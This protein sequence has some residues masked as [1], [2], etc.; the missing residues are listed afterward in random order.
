MSM[1]R[2]LVGITA[3]VALLATAVAA[4]AHDVRI[5]PTDE[6]LILPLVQADEHLETSPAGPIDFG[7]VPFGFTETREIDVENRSQQTQT[8]VIVPPPG[9]ESLLSVQPASFSLAPQASRRVELAYSPG[10]LGDDLSGEMIVTGTDVRG[11]PEHS[12]IPLN[13]TGREPVRRLRLVRPGTTTPI[14]AL[15]FGLVTVGDSTDFQVELINDGE[16]EVSGQIADLASF[17]SEPCWWDVCFAEAGTGADPQHYTLAAG[18][19]MILEVVFRPWREWAL[20]HHTVHFL[21]GDEPV[22]LALTVEALDPEETDD[23][24]V[25]GH[26][27]LSRTRHDFGSLAPASSAETTI[28]LANTGT[29]TVNGRLAGLAPGSHC[30]LTG[31][32]G[33]TDGVCF[34]SAD[35]PLQS[36]TLPPG[37]DRSIQVRFS[38]QAETL[39][40]AATVHFTGGAEPMAFTAVGSAVEGEQQTPEGQGGALVPIPID[41]AGM[42]GMVN[43]NTF[44]SSTGIDRVS[45]M[46]G[47]LVLSIPVGQ[48][49]RIGPS[50]SHGLSLTYNS[51]A[52]DFGSLTDGIPWGGNAEEPMSAPAYGSNAGLGWRLS[53]GE[54]YEKNG[55]A[56][57]W[58]NRTFSF[59]WLYV[60]PDGSRVY[61]DGTGTP[62][63]YH[64]RGTAFL[65]LVEDPGGQRVT[66]Q[67]GDGSQHVFDKTTAIGNGTATQCDRNGGCWLITGIEDAFG[68][69]AAVSY[70]GFAGAAPRMT[71][72]YPFNRRVTVD[73][74]PAI[75]GAGGDLGDMHL[76]VTAVTV[77]T[78]DGGS[79]TYRLNYDQ[80]TIVRGCPY[81]ARMVVNHRRM[82]VPLLRQLVVPHGDTYELRY[83]VDEETTAGEA[84]RCDLLAGT[85]S[86]VTLPTKASIEYRWKA[87]Q[88]PALCAPEGDNPPIGSQTLVAPFTNSAGVAE[89]TLV[90]EDGRR[91]AYTLYR[92]QLDPA[93]L[94]DFMPFNGGCQRRNLQITDVVH[95]PNLGSEEAPRY[96]VERFFHTVTR[97]GTSGVWG[98]AA[99][100][101]PINFA[102]SIPTQFGTAWLSREVAECGAE[103]FEHASCSVQRRHYRRYQLLGGS[104]CSPQEDRPECHR[105]REAVHVERDAYSGGKWIDRRHTDWD[106]RGHYRRTES[107]SNFRYDGAILTTWNHR[108]Y[109]GGRDLGFQDSLPG[110]GEKWLLDLFTQTRSNTTGVWRAVDSHFDS[111]T[112]ALVC[113]RTHEATPAAEE[114]IA[115]SNEDIA[116]RTTRNGSGY[117]TREEVA[118][119]DGGELPPA[120]CPTAAADMS[121]R[122]FHEYSSGERSRSQP[123]STSGADL[124]PPSLHLLIDASTGLPKGACDHGTQP[125]TCEKYGYDRLGRRTLVDRGWKLGA[126][127]DL[128]LKPAPQRLV[129]TEFV[130][131]TPAAGGAVLIAR[132][133]QG[134]ILDQAKIVFDGLGNEQ[135]QWWKDHLGRWVR[136]TVFTHGRGFKT[137]ETTPWLDGGTLDC[138]DS[139]TECRTVFRRDIYGRTTETKSPALNRH[140]LPAPVDF[141][142]GVRVR[143]FFERGGGAIHFERTER[144]YSNTRTSR[145]VHRDH[146]GRVLRV[147]EGVEGTPTRRTLIDRNGA[148]TVTTLDPLEGGW[149]SQQRRESHDGRGFLTEEAY[150]EWSGQ[151]TVYTYDARG[152]PRTV[153]RPDGTVL[154]HQRDA[155]GRVVK[156]R[157]QGPAGRVLKEFEYDDTT[158]RLSA[159]VRWNDLSCSATFAFSLCGPDAEAKVRQDFDYD[160]NG[161][162][163]G[164]RTEIWFGNTLVSAVEQSWQMDAQGQVES[165]GYPV[166]V[167]GSQCPIDIAP[168][169]TV[170]YGYEHGHLVGIATDGRTLVEQSYHPNG[171]LSRID[172]F[173]AAG[174][175]S[176]YEVIGTGDFGNPVMKGIEL[177]RN[178]ADSPEWSSGEFLYSGRGTVRWLFGRSGGDFAFLYDELDR[179]TQYNRF[180]HLTDYAYDPYDNL[181]SMTNLPGA[182]T[183]LIYGVSSASNRVTSHNGITAISYDPLG[184]LQRFENVWIAHDA[185]GQQRAYLQDAGGAPD[186]GD[187]YGYQ[188][189]YLYDADDRRVALFDRIP[190][191]SGPAGERRTLQLYLRDRTGETLREVQTLW[192]ADDLEHH[193][194][195]DRVWAAG[196]LRAYDSGDGGLRHVHLDHLGSPKTLTNGVA[197]VDTQEFDPWGLRIPGTGAIEIRTA[198][199]GHEIDRNDPAALAT[200]GFGVTYHLGARSYAPFLGRFLSPDPARDPSSWTLYGYAG[201]DPM[202]NGDLAGLACNNM[203]GNTGIECIVRE[204]SMEPLE[205]LAKSVGDGRFLDAVKDPQRKID[206]ETISAGSDGVGKTTIAPSTGEILSPG[207]RAVAPAIADVQR[208][209]REHAPERS[210]RKDGGVNIHGEIVV[211]EKNPKVRDIAASRPIC[212]PCAATLD[213]AGIRTASPRKVVKAAK[214]LPGALGTAGQLLGITVLV[215]DLRNATSTREGAKLVGEFFFGTSEVGCGQIEGC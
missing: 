155:L 29:A 181:L 193:G 61:F 42:R 172:H 117:V 10:G 144:F 146:L 19:S 209:I 106:G 182:G 111:T 40:F 107:R 15:D 194:Y 60:T 141:L 165:V 149:P 185:F 36:F 73:Y 3:W 70:L 110:V 139:G 214:K 77:P 116:V 31:D 9:T 16:M 188:A 187:G 14:T 59:P 175:R 134:G 129:D 8:V 45:T 119:G 64:S 163:D 201:N 6:D 199:G 157:A 39:S 153:S 101:L 124:G 44:L 5:L 178:G 50:M 154:Y 171:Q 205:R 130:Y 115:P 1:R 25:D 2:A 197:V 69:R 120:G 91:Q 75:A 131:Q 85:V 162:L 159:A 7:A 136:R 63:V 28:V 118:G 211:M 24:V 26:L 167:D 208:G 109:R 203:I 176:W 128:E 46:T 108:D 102:A 53:L 87:W 83:N 183:D 138:G 164:R 104:S 103:D 86:R 143:T 184:R 122:T 96:K 121:F 100:G 43:Q 57:H 33:P 112:G 13:G 66:L 12:S 137:A 125:A 202:A 210:N 145:V 18:E 161:F 72:T 180:G 51:S 160:S 151:A 177:F 127:G 147:L 186:P 84:D 189:I 90:R 81:N 170:D 114:A 168:N 152:K 206:G 92:P 48:P 140:D 95:G 30:V 32:E 58:P 213:E 93:S 215:N 37:G 200:D 126:E 82:S 78:F 192:D 174:N 65:R 204:G 113:Q 94:E 148:S 99:Y 135:Q 132:L 74:S 11:Y 79:F 17:I 156:V 191:A 207:Q 76:A 150:P 166:C 41:I 195:R 105:W 169:R 196:Q 21:G 4:P 52:W 190:D 56:P 38:P 142:S 20:T 123:K 27:V 68:N 22:D 179:L 173:E 158:G 54:L 97:P 198:F 49:Q 47:N 80:R 212:P 35:Q 55:L 23:V 71:I 62:G 89:R 98:R 88:L 133:R 34:Y 67:F